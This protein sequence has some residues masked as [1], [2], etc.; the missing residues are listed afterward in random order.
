MTILQSSFLPLLVL[1]LLGSATPAF[2]QRGEGSLRQIS[3]QQPGQPPSARDFEQ[4]GEVTPLWK[5]P[6]GFERDVFTFVRIRY[7]SFGGGFRGGSRKWATDFPDA[8]LNFSWRLQQMTSLK[9]NPRPIFLEIT[10]PLLFR[11]P[12]IYICEAGQLTFTDEEIP[13]L[14]RYLLNGGFLMFDDFWGDG[15]WENVA[16]QMKRVFPDRTFTDL[17]RKHPLFSAVF[18]LPETLNL[19]CPNIRLGTASQYDGR[20]WERDDGDH[21]AHIRGISDDKGRLMVIACHN[22]DNGDGWEREGENA[23]YFREFSEKKA[24]PL[25][26]NI[27]FY[28]MT[29]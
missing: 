21:E 17:P 11:Y 18:P 16:E 15:E 29:H 2:A 22:T 9:V 19:Q 7:S 23:Y 27:I 24:Y 8:D 13:I 14:R 5:N 20:T 12:F 26:I 3:P 25:G 10:D 6:E 28:M 4:N 1:L